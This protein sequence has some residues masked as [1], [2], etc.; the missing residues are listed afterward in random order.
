MTR[1]QAPPRTFHGH[2]SDPIPCNLH[3]RE[4]LGAIASGIFSGTIVVVIIIAWI[5]SRVR[6]MKFFIPVAKSK[7][8]EEEVYS[9]IK[10]FLAEVG[11]NYPNTED[12]VHAILYDTVSQIYFI[13]TTKRGVKQGS[14]IFCGENEV[15]FVEDFES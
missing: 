15:I 6:E 12:Q 13:C 7:A 14:P 8:Q 3:R 4:V 1:F 2:G 11:M 9:A 5:L 10:Q